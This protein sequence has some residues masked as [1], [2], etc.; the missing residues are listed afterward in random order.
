MPVT[1]MG[2]YPSKVSPSTTRSGLPAVP[3]CLTLAR[4]VPPHVGERRL[5]RLPGF[6]L[7]ESPL[8]RRRS[9]WRPDPPLGFFPSRG[10]HLRDNDAR[11]VVSSHGLRLRS[12]NLPRPG[13]PESRS[14]RA[15]DLSS[16]TSA[17]PGVLAPRTAEAG[18]GAGRVTHDPRPQGTPHGG[19][20]Q[21]ETAKRAPGPS[22]YRQAIV[23]PWETA[24]R[25]QRGV[26]QP[27]PTGHCG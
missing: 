14:R 19:H 4:T 25:L 23:F 9:G 18:V 27:A 6:I 13:P 8:P 17:P 11:H 7:R 12:V 5:A 2:L 1:L 15:L 3:A 16:E 20:G 26:K 21:P 22:E 10:V 24:R